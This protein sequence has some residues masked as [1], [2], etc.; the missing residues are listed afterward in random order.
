MNL[1]DVIKARRSVRKFKRTPISDTIINELIESARLAPS[2]GNA[3][4][5][6]F[7]II[8]DESLRRQ[9]AVAAGEQMWIASAPV[10]IAGCS[11]I[12]WDIANQP[13]D[14]F[15]VIVN[16]LRFGNSFIAD[17]KKYPN[18]RAFLKLYHNGSPCIPMEHIFLTAVSHGLNACFV[19][20]LDIDKASEILHLP[21]NMAC[22]FL[23]PVGYADEAPIEKELKSID[24][25]S[26]YDRWISK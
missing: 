8:R 16:H 2:A 9:L 3:Q 21:K 23:L 13:E 19:G 18:R 25:I 11:D 7:G 14:D 24:E 5:H 4:N 15:G 6:V 10:V 17:M 1:I 22:L 20:H 26:F 12:S